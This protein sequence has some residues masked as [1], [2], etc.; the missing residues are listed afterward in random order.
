MNIF[1]SLGKPEY[2]YRPRQILRR[3]SR[4]LH[5]PNKLEEIVLPWGL[6]ICINPGESIGSCIWRMGLYDLNV[7][8]ALW[9]LCDPG[10]LALDIGANIGQMTGLLALRL[11]TSGKVVALEPHP[12]NFDRLALNISLWRKF[13]GL[14]DI[15]ILRK[16]ASDRT[17][18]AQLFMPNYF[19]TNRGT[20]SLEMHDQ[21]SS[22]VH[23]VEIVRID[24]LIPLDSDIGVMKIDV[25]GH[26]L[27][28]LEGMAKLF[29]S[30]AVRDVVFEEHRT[31]PT[32]VTRWFEERDYHI[33]YLS[34]TIR[35]PKISRLGT[36]HKLH[37]EEA[38]NYIA[39]N[40]PQRALDRF[41][42]SGWKVLG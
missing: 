35:G 42:H 37:P 1:R 36:S 31:P 9:R 24:E 6:P 2:L 33:F 21:G 34:S 23:K 25:E 41:G 8:E 17:G 39:T 12:D 27:C 15:Q 19:D 10:E 29:N 3:L 38:P 11:G 22:S 20:A 5:A 7:C 13:N 30:G 26:E 32:S 18:S 14:G 16:G 4:E 28:A 40:E